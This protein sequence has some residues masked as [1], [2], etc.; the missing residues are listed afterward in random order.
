MEQIE[1]IPIFIC[2]VQCNP[3][4]M[5]SSCSSDVTIWIDDRMDPQR[6]RFREVI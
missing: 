4:K 5:M 2:V 1:L 6:V 3:M